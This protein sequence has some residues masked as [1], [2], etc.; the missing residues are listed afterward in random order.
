M[1]VALASHRRRSNHVL[2]WVAFGLCGAL[3][4]VTIFHDALFHRATTAAPEPPSGPP[5]AMST[6][7]AMPEGA[8][9][10]A[11]IA[12]ELARVV[13]LASEVGVPGRI[14]ANSD[15]RVDIRPR[16]SGVIREVRASL[17]QKVKKGDVLAVLDSADIGTERL[18]LRS[19]Q[20]ELATTRIEQAWR[21]QVATNVAR[22]IPELRRGIP[23]L[24]I[25][26]KYADRPLGSNRALLLEA[27]TNFEIASHEE[28]KTSGLHK[29]KIVGEHPYFLAMH[30][31]EG[32]RAKFE[33]ALEQVRYDANQQKLVSDQQ[34][35]GAEAA[36]I[37][38]AQ[39]LRILGVTENVDDLL[40][41]AS[42]AARGSKDEDVT[43]YPIAAPFDGTI[44]AKAAVPS[45]RA[46]MNDVLFGLADLTTVR[47]VASVYE[48]D[49]SALQKLEDGTIR[50]SAAA[51][52]GRTF[53]A[54]L[55]SVGSVVDPATRTVPILAE[56]P[57][58]DGILKLGMFARIVL[59]RRETEP[60]LTV[61]VSSVVE[62]EGRKAVF[63]PS[64]TDG[65]TFT[66]R[67]VKLG[68]ES[69]DRQVVLSGVNAGQ[70]VVSAGAFYLKS[71]LVLQNETGED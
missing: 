5:P 50:F 20:R 53:E 30:T 58:P 65:R 17:G 13:E 7:V 54:K 43:A 38:A 32:A 23:A 64:G 59:D 69:G 48:S 45:Q 15:R 67:P 49:F 57:N 27:Y 61:P 11:G 10:A 2:P 21:D 16:A 44:I 6:T 56:T 8:F 60:A 3:L 40:A 71:A 35:A 29:E 34:V 22:L 41:H 19:R 55:L 46:E 42:D 9:K 52:P 51:Y 33:A 4:G 14:E 68:R 47:V 26:K 24:E 39:R 31:R 1:S 63:V 12:I 18:N 37:D 62:I 66:M 36:V 25:E 28:E 70:P